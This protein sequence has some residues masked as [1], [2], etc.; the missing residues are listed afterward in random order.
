M[1]NYVG[2]IRMFAGNYAPLG[3]ALCNGA[4]LSISQY[5]ALYSLL[6]T[7]WG[8]DGRTNFAL[9]DLV[10]RIPV[11][12]DTTGT[13]VFTFGQ[14]FGAETVVLTAATIPA[15]THG[16]EVTTNNANQTVPGPNYTFGKITQ[17]TSYLPTMYVPY[18]ASVTLNPMDTDTVSSAGNNVGHNNVMPSLTINFIIALTGTYPQRQS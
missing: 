17:T 5:E 10:G 9:P 1:D 12:P 7:S 15:H 16:F 3:W 8:G 6:G 4:L 14:K 13:P 2:E 18:D 11:G